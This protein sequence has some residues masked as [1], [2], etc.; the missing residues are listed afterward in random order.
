MTTEAEE[1]LGPSPDLNSEDLWVRGGVYVHYE[2]LLEEAEARLPALERDVARARYEYEITQRIRDKTTD[3][4]ARDDWDI[5]ASVA[6]DFAAMAEAN[7]A[8]ETE[9]AAWYRAM[10]AEIEADLGDKAQEYED[11]LTEFDWEEEWD[12]EDFDEFEGFDPYAPIPFMDD[13]DE[14]EDEDE[15]SAGGYL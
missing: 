11:I 13:E 3:P 2:R 7:L 12:E 15:D 10:V 1:I 8:E 6:H 9:D 14:W 5:R 4:E